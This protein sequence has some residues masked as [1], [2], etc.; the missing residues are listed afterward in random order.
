MLGAS[1]ELLLLDLCYSYKA[2]LDKQGDSTATDTFERKV[3][4]ARCAHDRL[5]EFLK[6]ANSNASLFKQLGFEDVNLNF[7]F[8]DII[9]QTR[10]DGG[11]PTGNTISIEQFKMLLTNY[12][13]FLPMILDAIAKLPHITL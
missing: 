13:H 8:F 4:S 11:H 5:I 3:V 10:N 6:R 7:S 1:A 12:Q 2:F 9:R